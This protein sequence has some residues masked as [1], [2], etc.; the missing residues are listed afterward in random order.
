MRLLLVTGVA[1]VMFTGCASHHPKPLSP[2]QQASHLE[3]RTLDNAELRGFIQRN[4]AHPPEQWPVVTWDLP[5]LTLV[6]LYYHPDMDVARAHW[7]VAQAAE[8][9]AGMRPNPSLSVGAQRNPGPAGAS[10]W[11]L[12]LN[13]DIPVETAG[14]RGYRVGQASALSEAARLGI[15]TA[16]WQVRARVRAALLDL[17]AAEQ[18]RAP[19]ARQVQLQERVVTMLQ[20]RLD[21][22]LIASP[23]LTA[24]QIQRTQSALLLDDAQRRLAGARTALASALGLS[25]SALNGLAVAPLPDAL[26]APDLKDALRQA[27]Q[28]RADVLRALAEYTASESAL[29]LQIANQYPDLH[30]GPGYTWDQ[31]ASKWLLRLTLSLPVMNRNE[32]PIAEA[33]A[34]RSQ[35]M[36]AFNGVQS[37]A[38]A[39]VEAAWTAC[40]ASRQSLQ[41]LA[42]LAAQRR[43]QLRRAS[44]SL[45]MG[46]GDR[47]SRVTA[48]IELAQ[49]EVAQ[50]QAQARA[51]KALGALEDAVQSPLSAPELRTEA[52]QNNPRSEEQP[53]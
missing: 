19:L 47:L 12:G 40:Q 7:S 10:P 44:Q 15:A 29:Q 42:S 5:L 48:E 25:V 41:A 43:T 13:L 39:E 38:L 50:G 6:A 46:Q 32:G 4:L 35:A 23:E 14:K 2:Q 24:A 22:G 51:A 53:Q 28:K 16:A 21:A 9:T 3:A 52:L 49:V 37:H 11:T 31:G 27:L 8:I 20:H 36:A 18:A 30:L 17:Q 26:P 1:A 45:Q 33:L 34:R